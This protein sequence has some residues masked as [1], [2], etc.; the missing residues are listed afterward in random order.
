MIQSFF[1]FLGLSN[2]SGKKLGYCQVKQKT[3]CHK[4]VNIMN[5]FQN[6]LATKIFQ[7]FE[8]LNVL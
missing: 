6:G 3:A 1:L 4:I 5:Q 2:Q 7:N 8:A